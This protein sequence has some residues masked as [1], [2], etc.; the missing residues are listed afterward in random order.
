MIIVYF[1]PIAFSYL[2]QRPQHF[3]ELLS[4]EH[5]FYYIEP[6]KRVLSYLKNGKF[7]AEEYKVNNNLTV[8]RC[9][10]KF[11]LPFRWNVF[12]PFYL[13]GLYEYI[14][15][16]RILQ[17][18]D[19]IIVGFEGWYNVIS[20]VKNKKIIYDKM[21]ENSLLSNISGNQVYLQKCETKLIKKSMAMFASAKAF[22]NK[23]KDR[24]P[25]YLIPNAFDGV[26]GT[27]TVKKTTSEN[28]KIFGYVGTIAEWF[29]NEAIDLIAENPNHQVVLVGPYETNKIDRDNIVYIG[30]VEKKE[31][32]KYIR[33]FDVCLYPFKMSELLDTI[34][35]VKI[36]EYLSFNKP[37]IA[38]SNEEIEGFDANIYTYKNYEELKKLCNQTLDQPFDTIEQYEFFMKSN[39]WDNRVDKINEILEELV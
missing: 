24:L 36:Y 37:I 1:S 12:D 33:S 28:K 9:D 32:A 19:V 27:Y 6:T 5:Q 3:A 13:N 22:V 11:V 2:K 18:T 31:I 34:N 16:R 21:D 39:N 17:N 15:L 20:R 14:Q 29:D 8:F 7:K 38:V 23:Y 30:K 4:K 10:G 35:P 26:E 25:V